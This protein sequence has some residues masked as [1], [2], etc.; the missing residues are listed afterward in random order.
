MILQGIYWK[1][2]NF[3]VFFTNIPRSSPN[4]I[5]NKDYQI[6]YNSFHYIFLSDTAFHFKLF[7]HG[8]SLNT[9]KSCLYSSS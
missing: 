9:P 8:S 5:H 7:Y 3:Y 1:F 6:Y 2:L 4:Y